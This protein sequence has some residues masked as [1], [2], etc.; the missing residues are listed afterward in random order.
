MNY[1]SS[2]RSGSFMEPSQ[3]ILDLLLRKV[4]ASASGEQEH[5]FLMDVGRD[6]AARF[7]LGEAESLSSL[8]EKINDLWHM[9]DLGVAAITLGQ[10][11]VMIRHD[12]PDGTGRLASAWRSAV[13]A[14]VQGSYD[15]WL[16]ALGSGPRLTTSQVG[17]SADHVEF[18]HGA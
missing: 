9:L 16:R 2:H 15:A 13:P 14:I 8:E 17:Q 10:D 11:A 18:R 4:H 7:P 12:L 5:A 6:L 3:L 1:V